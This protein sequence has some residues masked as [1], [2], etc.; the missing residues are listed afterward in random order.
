MA[1]LQ[2]EDIRAYF[3]FTAA[4][5]T[6]D[7]G[8]LSAALREAVDCPGRIMQQ[9]AEALQLLAGAG[10]RCRPHLVSDLWVVAEILAGALR[11]VY[12][13]G[14]ANLKLVREA[15]ER[16]ALAQRLDQARQEGEAAYQQ[17]QQALTARG[18]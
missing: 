17:A 15:S 7:A 3:N 11:G 4:R 14:A 18:K 12:H 9:A 13:I 10:E 1:R 5:A 6:G 16:Q 8:L 2:A